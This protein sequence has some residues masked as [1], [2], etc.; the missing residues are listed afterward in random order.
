MSTLASNLDNA[1]VNE[2]LYCN[3][4]TSNVYH[5]SYQLSYIKINGKQ[6]TVIYTDASYGNLKNG[7]SQGAYL[8]FLMEENN[9]CN[10]L[11]WQSKQVKRVA[12]R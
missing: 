6:K 9:F 8:I 4:I 11:S 1:T 7:G 3:K 2:I 12:Q 5:N 10:L